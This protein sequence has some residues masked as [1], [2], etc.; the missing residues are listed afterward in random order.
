MPIDTSSIGF[1]VILSIAVLVIGM[2]L[3]FFLLYAYHYK[4]E[5]INH[6]VAAARNIVTMAESVRGNIARQW[7]YGLFSPGILRNV[8]YTG[9]EDLKQKVLSA[10]PVVAAWESAK[11]I[12]KAGGFEFKTP[13]QNPRN[14][15]NQPDEVEAAALEYFSAHPE[16][17]EFYTQDKK[18][19]SLRYFHPIRLTQECLY[20]HGDPAQS[21]AFWRRDDGRDITGFAMEGKKEGE[22]HGAFEVVKSLEETDARLAK[23]LGVSAALVI[24]LLIL[25]LATMHWI[26]DR[27]VTQPINSALTRLLH[28]QERGDLAFRLDESGKDEIGRLGNGFNRFVARLQAICRQVNHSIAEVTSTSEQL[29]RVS[30]QTTESMHDLQTKTERVVAAM[31]EMGVTVDAVSRHARAGAEAASLAKDETHNGKAVVLETIESIHQL[32]AEVEKAAEA[33]TQVKR[34]SE[35]IGVILDVVKGIADQTN[36][37]ALNAPSRRPAPAN[38]DA[39]SPW[40]PTRYAPCPCAPNSPPC[41]FKT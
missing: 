32:S 20:C 23:T 19:N 12:S 17:T 31:N 22:L 36:L 9:E 13:R 40:W 15:S 18:T 7:E 24:A 4:S 10:A 25:M 28:A 11:A 27:M 6:E 3:L 8:P 34:D 1:R 26:A 5:A 38:T 39:D 35:Q 21:H 41:R 30:D 33:I 14:P 37:L 16:Q 29:S 2:A